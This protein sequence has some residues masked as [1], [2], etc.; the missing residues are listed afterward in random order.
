MK[1]P[2]SHVRDRV[3]IRKPDLGI[4]HNDHPRPLV[5]PHDRSYH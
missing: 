4:M 1:E 3:V 5:P 2:G